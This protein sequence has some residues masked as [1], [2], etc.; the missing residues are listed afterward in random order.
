MGITVEDVVGGQ[1][2][3]PEFCSLIVAAHADTVI[4]LK[5]GG[6]QILGIQLIDIDQQIPCPINR[7]MLE[8]VTK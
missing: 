5:D 6:I 2:C 8:I 7:L 3:L 4:T 1:V